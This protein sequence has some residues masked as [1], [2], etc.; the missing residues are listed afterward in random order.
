M[1]ILMILA[2]LVVAGAAEARDKAR[3]PGYG[4]VNPRS[5]NVAGH[6]KRD[7]TYIAPHRRTAP[8]ATTRDNYSA[9]GNYN[10]WKPNNK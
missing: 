7:G 3:E 10:P 2:M 9:P 1:R 5:G 4:W 6:L 8:N